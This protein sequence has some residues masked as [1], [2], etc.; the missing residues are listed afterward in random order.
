LGETGDIPTR[1]VNG[2]LDKFGGFDPRPGA[3]AGA[4]SFRPT[5]MESALSWL[6]LISGIS[7]LAFAGYLTVA[8]YTSVPFLDE[9][10]V[11]DSLVTAP[12]PLP[13]GWLV[14]QEN[15]HRFFFYR[16]LL[17][18]DLRLSQ[19]N[20]VLIFAS[21]YA[22]QLAFLA[23]IAWTLRTIGGIR[24]VLWRT[25]V[26][27]AAY[28]LFCPSQWENFSWAIQLSVFLPGFFLFLALVSV[29]LY[30][31]QDRTAR[32]RWQY[33]LLSIMAAASATYSN[34]NGILVWPVLI[35]FAVLLKAPP[36]VI[37]VVVGACLGFVAPYFIHYT[38]PIQHARPLES[39]R[40]PLILI[41]YVAKYFGGS[42]LGRLALPTGVAGLLVAAVLVIRAIFRREIKRPMTAVLF[43]MILFCLATA[44]VTALG[45][46]NF[47]TDQAY[48][49]RY[50]TI[51][52]LFWLSLGCLTFFLVTG[53]A[54]RTLLLAAVVVVMLLSAVRFKTPLRGAMEKQ[55]RTN[56]GSFALMTGIL[57]QKAIDL[58]FPVSPDFWRQFPP[59]V[60]NQMKATI[61]N[62][63]VR[64]SQ[65]L[66]DRR[67]SFFSGDLYRRLNQPLN[68]A[69]QIEPQQACVG[70]VDT[71]ERLPMPDA[72]STGL[73]VSGWAVDARSRRP[74]R[75]IVASANGVVVGFGEAGFE[76]LDPG[77]DLHPQTAAGSG[78]IAYAR[79][80]ATATSVEI[81]GVV[82]DRREVCR[83][84][85]VPVDV[86]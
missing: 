24:G 83:I 60:Q 16:L 43:G 23:L 46:I 44:S 73:R 31:T 18:A 71:V 13:P 53:R 48:S 45:R 36:R 65:Y 74:V 56:L 41:E 67:L 40:H 84:A 52:L 15:E 39:L 63:L 38:T 72:N 22:V 85:G 34:A 59:E 19:G 4:P 62:M 75:R 47:G 50:Q 21:I 27:G 81:Y 12:H 1:A 42:F 2:R 7:T 69:Y 17:L 70:Y 26:G 30:G 57:D 76:Q 11:L 37:A 55:A 58:L 29:A 86:R 3:V 6:I 32:R 20:Y 77:S 33:V 28:C 68:F 80:P 49:S 78:W 51:A 5:R 66:R 35:C 8:S 61:A 25:G 9:W 64:D 10:V 82:D 14:L 54:F 79:V